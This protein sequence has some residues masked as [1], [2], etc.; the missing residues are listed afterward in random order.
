MKPLGRLHQAKV[1]NNVTTLEG[2]L[3][4]APPS[5]LVHLLTVIATGVVG[6]TG[7]TFDLLSIT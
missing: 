6:A 1:F 5:R 7:A 4:K 3:N 2:K